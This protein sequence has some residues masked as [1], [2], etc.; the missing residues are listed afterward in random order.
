MP[1]LEVDV[2][3]SDGTIWSGD[4]R[5]VSAP[6][7]D[8]EIGVLVGHTPVLSVLRHGEVRVL[9]NAGTTH[10]WAVEGGFLSVDADQVTIV[11]DSAESTTTGGTTR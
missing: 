3:D 2:V 10:R 9:D 1:Q 7:S 5:R 11:V 4:A 6:A 8:G